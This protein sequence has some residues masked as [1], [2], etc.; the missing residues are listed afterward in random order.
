MR[1]WLKRNMRARW[2]L[3]NLFIG[4]AFAPI[5]FLMESVGRRR[6]WWPDS[7]LRQLL[8]NLSA[9]AAIVLVA[10][11]AALIVKRVSGGAD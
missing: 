10:V 8:L 7:Y 6:G 1:E 3:V 2:P 11:V 9:A 4:I 5:I